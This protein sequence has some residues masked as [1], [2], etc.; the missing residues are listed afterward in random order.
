MTEVSLTI[1]HILHDALQVP[2]VAFRVERISRNLKRYAVLSADLLCE[3][4]KRRAHGKAHLGTG[5]FHPFFTSS[6]ILIFTLTVCAI[7][8]TPF[9]LILYAEIKKNTSIFLIL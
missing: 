4:R 5:P 9:L 1:L 6:S 3:H 8:N 2:E 7:S